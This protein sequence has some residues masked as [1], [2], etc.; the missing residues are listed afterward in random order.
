M[1]V[2]AENGAPSPPFVTRVAPPAS[3]MG[4]LTPAGAGAAAGHARRSGH[5]ATPID[6]VSA[7]EMLSGRLAPARA[8]GGARTGAAAEEEVDTENYGEAPRS[9]R[10]AEAPAARRTRPGPT[11]CSSPVAQTIA[12]EVTRGIFGALLGKRPRRRR[13]RGFF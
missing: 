4:P 2:L 8:R 6:R 1:T 9:R 3:R 13:T 10:R 11:C 5:Y 12:R 7:H